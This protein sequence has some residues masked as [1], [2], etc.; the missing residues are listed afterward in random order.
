MPAFMAGLQ[1]KEDTMIRTEF[2]CKQYRDPHLCRGY[3]QGRCMSCYSSDSVMVLECD[4]CGVEL[5]P[6]EP[7][8]VELCERCKANR[9][10]SVGGRT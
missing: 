7:L 10:G 6:D 8:D 2:M 3:R 5:F 4:R 9:C 1:I